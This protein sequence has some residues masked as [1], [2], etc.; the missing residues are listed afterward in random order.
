MVAWSIEYFKTFRLCGGEKLW[1]LATIAISHANA[2]IFVSFRRLVGILNLTAVPAVSS[3]EKYPARI[4]QV[5]LFYSSRRLFVL[6]SKSSLIAMREE[7]S[8]FFYGVRRNGIKSSERAV[9]QRKFIK[10]F[11]EMRLTKRK[12]AE[13]NTAVKGTRVSLSPLTAVLLA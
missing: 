10:R 5:K 13:N 1:L 3:A 7:Y 11:A 2:R 4:N 9:K 6:W 8:R 12:H